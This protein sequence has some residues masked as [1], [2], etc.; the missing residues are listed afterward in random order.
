M[1]Q[2]KPRRK[3]LFLITKATWG[4]AQK[5][6]FDLATNVPKEEFEAMVAYGERGRLA[7]MLEKEN[8]ATRHIPSL[9]RDVAVVSDVS[10]LFQILICLWRDKPD[11]LHLNSSKAAALGALAGRI[12]FV[13][14]IIFT[15]HGWPF[16][17][18][19][20]ILAKIF[21]WK[22]SWV[23]ALLSHRVICVSDYDLQIARRMPLIG[24]KA[25]RIYN[26]I[27]PLNLGSGEKIRDAFPRGVK[28]T[29]TIGELTKNKNQIAL[30]EEARNNP[31]MHV[32]IVGFGEDYAMLNEKI[33]DYRL[34]NRVTLFGFLP[35][36]EALRG[37]DVFSLPSIKEGLP[38]V[39]LEAK[40]A[41]LP[42]I[43][44]RVGGVGEVLDAKDMS[45]FSLP[46]MIE[47]T[48]GLYR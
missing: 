14:K 3:V 6:V 40:A 27:A 44:N 18:K 1:A 24:K 20:N 31:E 19:R 34:E 21:I 13:R 15:V 46:T 42:I 29:G 16:G 7:E 35:V 47:R 39:L 28:I 32:A 37:F 25:V 5:Y 41:G 4:G 12:M 36:G 38:Y 48:A 11:V 22:I 17:E 45:E 2:N 33:K 8:I 30:I 26:G 23:T 10:S 9:G 43:A